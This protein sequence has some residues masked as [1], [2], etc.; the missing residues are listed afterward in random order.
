MTRQPAA[1]APAWVLTAV[2]YDGPEARR[3]TQALH[4]E[5]LAT[6]GFADDPAD[7]VSGEFDPPHGT[8][9]LASAPG[10]PA[11]ACCGWRTAGPGTAEFKRLY[12]EPP[13]RGQGLARRLVETLEQHARRSGKTRVILET[14]ARSHAALALF[15]SCGFTFTDSYVEGRN[16]DINRAMQKTLS[17]SA[18]RPAG[19]PARAASAASPAVG[20]EDALDD[21]VVAAGEGETGGLV[22]EADVR[23]PARSDGNE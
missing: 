21:R 6:Y 14:G 10:G 3:L 1:A 16:P 13:A 9:L 18:A 23:G 12:V 2:S 15:T 7:T 17:P 8:F 22:D 11:V 19:Q 20:V 4:R 5:Q